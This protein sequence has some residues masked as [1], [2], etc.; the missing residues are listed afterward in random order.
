MT[1]NYVMKYFT[2]FVLM[3]FLI[4]KFGNTFTLLHR[5]F[6]TALKNYSKRN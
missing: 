1:F 3:R 4:E 6:S 5:K 2:N